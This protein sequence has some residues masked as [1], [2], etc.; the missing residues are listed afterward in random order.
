[1]PEESAAQAKRA[2]VGLDVAIRE[3]E[4]QGKAEEG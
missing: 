4:A 3:R 2:A 1:M